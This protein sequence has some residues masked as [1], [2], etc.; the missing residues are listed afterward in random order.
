VTLTPGAV[1]AQY[2]ARYESA[3]TADERGALAFACARELRSLYEANSGDAECADSYAQAL[4]ELATG[5]GEPGAVALRAGARELERIARE[6]YFTKLSG[7][8]RAALD[9]GAAV[10]WRRA[11]NLPRARSAAVRWAKRS[12]ARGDALD[13]ARAHS[14]ALEVSLER[15]RTRQVRVHAVRALRALR[16]DPAGA[17]AA[18]TYA[19]AEAFRTAART[20]RSAGRARRMALGFAR[21]AERLRSQGDSRGTSLCGHALEAVAVTSLAARARDAGDRARALVE[22][23]QLRLSAAKGEDA[24]SMAQAQHA[25]A[26]ELLHAAVLVQARLRARPS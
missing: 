4:L 25:D 2:E 14:F 24:R 3:Q 8:E 1:R 20:A 9:E 7:P 10:A 18:H 17:D 5:P 19:L 26:L 21:A 16:A 13:A 23:A 12:L 15:G 6:R 22:H 11:G